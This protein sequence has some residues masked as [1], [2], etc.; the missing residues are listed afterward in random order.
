MVRTSRAA[1]ARALVLT[2]M[3]G[4]ALVTTANLAGAAGS[5]AKSGR[6]IVVLKNS[7]RHPAAVS[8]RQAKES[9][10]KVSFF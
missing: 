1:R 9:G 8:S 4:T 6:Y 5:N 10:S 3:V 7:V 2:L